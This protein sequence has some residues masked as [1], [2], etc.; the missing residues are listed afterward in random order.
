[1]SIRT[2][3]RCSA[4]PW[5]LRP[6]VP[7]RCWTGRPYP[8]DI[9]LFVFHQA[10]QRII[11]FGEEAGHRPARCPGNIKAHRQQF[12]ASVPL[13]LDELRA[14][15]PSPPAKKPCVWASAAG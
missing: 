9:D 10:N 4:S 6:A 13:L 14:A 15:G 2:A 11:D 1:M 12:A 3:S 7:G 8:E 5:R